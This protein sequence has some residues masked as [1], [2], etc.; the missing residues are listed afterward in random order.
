M[1]KKSLNNSDTL[2]YELPNILISNDG[3]QI[4][5]IKEWEEIRR[6]EILELFK[7]N[8]YG[9]IPNVELDVKFK[10]SRLDTIA[11]N[12]NAIQ[13]EIIVSISNENDTLDMNILIYL[14]KYSRKPNPIFLGMNFYGNHTIIMDTNITITPNYVNNK[15]EFYIT[16]NQATHLSRGVRADRWPVERILERG[17]GIASIYYGDLDPDYHDGFK[18]GLHKLFVSPS[19][20]IRKPDEAGA[21]SVWAY[22]LSKAIDYFEIDDDINQNQVAVI[23]H[24]RLGKT[25]LW[26]G[27]VDE[28][29]AITISNNSGCGGAALSRRKTGE[30]LLNINTKFPHWFCENFHQYNDN[31]A[32]LPIDQHMLIGLVA[33]RPVY[34]ASAVDDNWADPIGEYL[35]LF[36]AGSVYNLY[37]E[38][39]LIEK[40]LPELNQ[41][42]MIG[43]M[44]YHIRSGGHGLTAY[45][46]ERYLD[47]ADIHFKE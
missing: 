30:T 4:K 33:P 19:G 16:N 2:N 24:S 14:P 8:V 35:S 1:H 7:K 41:P 43:K 34:V 20:D 46:W 18:N 45:D 47:F 5:S 29:I 40:I 11:L 13:K 9:R 26:A 27:A 23:G 10:V 12:G 31:E 3:K 6:P 42:S 17:Y 36:Y 15:P 37:N 21:I 32:N 25:A 39:I 38:E 28:R 22:G 44:G